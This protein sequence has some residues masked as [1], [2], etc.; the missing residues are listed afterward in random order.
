MTKPLPG[1]RTLTAAIA[2]IT[3]ATLGL[4]ANLASP[5][6]A[7]P[8]VLPAHAVLHGA[9]NPNIITGGWQSVGTFSIAQGQVN[10]FVSYDCPSNLPYAMDGA[11]AFNSVGQSAEVYLGFNGPRLDENPPSFTSWGWHFYFPGGAPA[12]TTVNLDVNC[13]KKM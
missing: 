12:N 4:V 9:L 6:S 11:F 1:R 10:Q 3:V 2:G 13:Q 8:P 5:A 7:Q